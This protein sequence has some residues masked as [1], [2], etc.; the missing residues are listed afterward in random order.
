[1]TEMQAE[2]RTTGTYLPELRR[3]RLNAGLTLTALEARTSEVAGRKVYRATIS[4]LENRRR[5]A[6]PRTAHALA[7]ALGVKVEELSASR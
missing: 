3:V 1:M 2:R 7:E 5:G 4:E 6:Y